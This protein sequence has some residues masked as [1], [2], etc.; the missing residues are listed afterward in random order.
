MNPAGAVTPES[1]TLLHQFIQATW[2]VKLVLLGLIGASL[3][4]WAVII[5]KWVRFAAL[6]R[7]AARFEAAVNSGR[8]LEDV[9]TAAGTAPR[10][11]R[12]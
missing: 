4:S 2:V 11:A 5:D 7:A 8:S 6:N 12:S 10:H 3:W 1:F 9:A